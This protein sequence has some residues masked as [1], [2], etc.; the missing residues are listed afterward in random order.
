MKI[1]ISLPITG[2]DET[3]QRRVAKMWQRYFESDGHVVTN[4]FDIKDMLDEYHINHNMKK[5]TWEQYMHE[6]LIELIT[7]D[8]LFLCDGWQDS[9]GCIEEVE[10]ALHF[11]IKFM[12]ERLHV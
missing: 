8:A 7:N 2:K 5:P 6:D 11:K 10:M 9:N 12:F 3:M 4:P 1:Y